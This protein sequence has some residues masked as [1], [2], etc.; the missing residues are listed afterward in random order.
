MVYEE[1]GLTCSF[2]AEIVKHDTVG[3]SMSK[4]TPNV[5]EGTTF[6]FHLQREAFLFL[7][8]GTA[9]EGLLYT[10]TKVYVVVFKEY[11]VK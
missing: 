3:T 7:V 8:C 10:P 6:N 2:D 1:N 9:V 11:H 5:I 4:H